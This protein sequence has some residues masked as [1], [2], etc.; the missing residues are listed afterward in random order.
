MEYLSVEEARQRDGLRLVLTSG[1]PGPFSEAAKALFRH[2]NVNFL[3]VRQVG[4]RDNPELVAWTRHRN[5]PI[6]LY[7]DE[8]PRVRWL[9]ILDLAE[10]LGTGASLFPETI[11]DRIRMVGLI[12]EIAGE[13]SLIWHA[14]ILMLHE[15]VLA[16]GEEKARLNPMLQDYLYDTSAVE[17]A[18]ERVLSVINYLTHYIRERDNG[19]LIGSG[20]TAADI[21]FAYV[22]NIIKPQSHDVN[23]MPQG[24]RTSY[25]LLEKLFDDFD[26]VLIEFRDRIFEQ[27]LELPLTF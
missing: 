22:S 9:E 27:H 11:D 12:N 14:R 17:P 15:T 20:F 8:A 16:V 3:P 19:Y 23:P 10:R 4:G 26:P 13:N 2:H 21:Y 24:L 25:E 7:N 5:A 1:V 6:A 18:R